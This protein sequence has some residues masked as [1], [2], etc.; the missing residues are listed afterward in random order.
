M[1]RE[2]VKDFIESGVEQV[3]PQ[4]GFDTG[5]ITEFNSN[6]SIDYPFAWLESLSVEPDIV[7]SVPFDN[8]SISLHICKL[9]K[10]DSKPEQYEGIINE[11]DLIAQR[12]TKKYNDVVSGYK[13]VT[14]SGLS[15]DPFIKKH[16]DCLTGV[17]LSFTLNAP[18]RTDL[19]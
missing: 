9:D 14:L 18:D 3:D 11:C 16:K 15:R 6:M 19:C 12:L 17:I 7:N 1:T 5:R 8:W 10:Q 4:I 2:E 13:L